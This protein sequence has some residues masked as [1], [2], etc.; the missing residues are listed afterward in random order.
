MD[1]KRSIQEKN[2]NTNVVIK[3]DEITIHITDIDAS[4]DENELKCEIM[5]SKNIL[6][7]HFRII[8]IRPTQSGNQTATI[9]MNRKIAEEVTN[10]GKIKIG[11]IQ[12]R[13]RKRVS[14][15]RCFRC[16]LFGHRKED[17]SNEDRSNLCLKC[18]K[19]G[20]MAKDCPNEPACI[21]WRKLGQQQGASH[22]GMPK[23]LQSNLGRGRAAHDLAYATAIKRDVDILVV[24]EPNRKIAQNTQWIKDKRADV[25]ILFLNK[26]LE[27]VEA[28]SAEGYIRVSLKKCHIFCCYISPNICFDEFKRQVDKMMEDVR[29]HSGEKIIMGDINAKSPMWGSPTCDKRGEYW[30]EW[31]STL[32][33]NT[34]NDGK[35]PTFVRRDTESY[36]DITCSTQNIQKSITDWEILDCETLTEHQYICFSIT[37]KNKKP[38]N[39]RRSKPICDWKIFK[40]LAT[41]R[42]TDAVRT[43]EDLEKVMREVY[44]TSLT[45]TEKDR[46]PFW[47]TPDIGVKRQEC[48]SPEEKPHG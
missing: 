4:I 28:S 39:P 31:M 20:H 25:G 15:Q 23:F 6:E 8:S 11:W 22:P 7:N 29:I 10:T 16:H 21:A 32:N 13:V 3:T 38:Q 26:R 45:T 5:K 44:R 19:T 37:T 41:W 9:A 18:T 2:Q 27:V 24:G 43:I 47:W 40:E 42:I 14:L 17:C 35:K 36:I 46:T 12:C 30:C 33:L 1:L 48:L 34:L